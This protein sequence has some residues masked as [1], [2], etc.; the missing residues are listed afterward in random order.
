MKLAL[1]RSTT[2]RDLNQ[3]LAKEFPFLKFQFYIDPKRT[4]ETSHVAR[5]VADNLTLGEVYDLKEGFINIHPNDSIASVEQKFYDEFALPVQVLRN[6]GEVWIETNQTDNLT[7]QK[8]NAI[9]KEATRPVRF[10]LYT[11]FL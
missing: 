6:M 8:Q 10:N 1:T 11:L 9:A 2:I 3:L 7:M 5:R 4:M